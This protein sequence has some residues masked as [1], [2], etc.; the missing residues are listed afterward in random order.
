MYVTFRE[1]YVAKAGEKSTERKSAR[2]L[3]QTAVLDYLKNAKETENRLLDVDLREIKLKQ[4]SQSHIMIV[5]DTQNDMKKIANNLKMRPEI[6]AVEWLD[7]KKVFGDK[8][9]LDEMSSFKSK[10]KKQPV[11]YDPEVERKKAEEKEN[12][13]KEFE[14]KMEKEFNEMKQAGKVREPVHYKGKA[15]EL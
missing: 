8:A 6:L 5:V 7:K 10:V 15:D 1:K 9:S 11:Q 14:E 4:A 13:E 2:E 12:K 3:F